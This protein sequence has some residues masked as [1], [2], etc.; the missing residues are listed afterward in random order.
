MKAYRTWIRNDDWLLSSKPKE[1]DP[2]CWVQLGRSRWLCFTTEGL[3]P[4][5]YHSDTLTP[6]SFVQ[7]AGGWVEITSSSNGDQLEVG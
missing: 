1:H 6:E 4:E 5:V 7:S 2:I 3:E